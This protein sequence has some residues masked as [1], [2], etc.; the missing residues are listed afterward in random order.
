MQQ[1][2]NSRCRWVGAAMVTASTPSASSGS[3][4][5]NAGQ[6]SA[7]ETEILRGIYEKQLARYRADAKAAERLLSVGQSPRDAR[8]LLAP[9]QRSLEPLAS[10]VA[11][12]REPELEQ[13]PLLHGDEALAHMQP[14]PASTAIT[15]A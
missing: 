6:P 15:E 13:V 7:R 10:V 9:W 1:S 3:T 4:P 11:Q 8:R 12:R 2:A 14:K 5:L